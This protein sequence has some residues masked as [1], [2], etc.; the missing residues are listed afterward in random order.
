MNTIIQLILTLTLGGSAV[1]ICLQILRF[2]LPDGSS[3]W[4]YRIG[5]LAIVLY[6]VPIAILLQWV[7]TKYV[8]SSAGTIFTPDL[9]IVSDISTQ[10]L[11]FSISMQM[12]VS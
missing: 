3:K 6:L 2:L 11:H 8:S 7:F 5:K 4:L 10:G 1:V 9:T 12:V